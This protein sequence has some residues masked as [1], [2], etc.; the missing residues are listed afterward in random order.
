MKK[1]AFSSIEIDK[2][3][4]TINPTVPSTTIKIVNTCLNLKTSSGG[5]WARNFPKVPTVPAP[6][7]EQNRTVRTGTYFEKFRGTGT[8]NFCG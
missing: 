5:W 1:N 4:L 3:R 2:F 6:V 8:F 7:L